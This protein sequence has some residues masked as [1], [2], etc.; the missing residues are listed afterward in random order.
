MNNRVSAIALSSLKFTAYYLLM[1]PVYMVLS[2]LCLVSS[3][4]FNYF[5]RFIEEDYTHVLVLVLI[6]ETA[7]S[8]VFLVLVVM[9]RAFRSLFYTEFIL[10]MGKLFTDNLVVSNCAVIGFTYSLFDR[11]DFCEE[12]LVKLTSVLFVLC[13]SN[14]L[15]RWS[16]ARLRGHC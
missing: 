12:T 2:P 7:V 5:L 4:L 11:Q 10:L 8:L 6:A 15:S 14:C 13:T 1:V 3:R 16:K 9:E